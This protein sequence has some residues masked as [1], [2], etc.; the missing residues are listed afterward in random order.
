[1][2]KTPVSASMLDAVS[3]QS[4]LL[5]YVQ[6]IIKGLANNILK[7]DVI[8]RHNFWGAWAYRS[9][10]V[11]FDLNSDDKRTGFH[12][13]GWF[14][15]FDRPEVLVFAHKPTAGDDWKTM[16]SLDLVGSFYFTLED[17]KKQK[18]LESFVN[19]NLTTI[20]EES[21]QY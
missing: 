6:K 13:Y 12:P 4:E 16:D 19:Q 15:Y 2:K 7:R 8:A 11:T 17:A 20:I 10:L 9:V 18:V 21:K 3:A 5:D 14:L 1:M